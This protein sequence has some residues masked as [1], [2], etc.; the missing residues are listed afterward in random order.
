MGV[1]E[2]HEHT[3]EGFGLG[4]ARI[5]HGR[6]HHEVGDRAGVGQVHGMVEIELHRIDRT[7]TP[8]TD[9]HPLAHRATEADQPLLM[10]LLGGVVHHRRHRVAIGDRGDVV[11][12]LDRFR[13]R[14]AVGTVDLG[15]LAG[16]EAGDVGQMPDPS[17]PPPRS[18]PH[19]V[20]H[21]VGRPGVHR[22]Q[23]R[24][25]GPV[26]HDEGEG[27]GMSKRV[28]LSRFGHPRPGGHRAGRA[29]LHQVPLQFGTRRRVPFQR[30]H[31][32]PVTT[33]DPEDPPFGERRHERP[34]HRPQRAPVRERDR[35]LHE[36]RHQFPTSPGVCVLR[37]A[38]ACAAQRSA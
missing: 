22:M 32:H 15:G 13:G 28:L 6:D 20:G 1:V 33:A 36:S 8:A 21:R 7:H 23:H 27:E 34:D 17:A 31:H 24:G 35:A 25:G 9:V 26:E 4:L 37:A 18:D 12:H 2:Q 14:P 11:H 29:D 30:R 3:G 10:G 16:H 38:V 19:A 5:L